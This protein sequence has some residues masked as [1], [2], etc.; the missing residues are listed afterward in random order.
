MS[1][2]EVVECGAEGCPSV[3]FTEVVTF[4]KVPAVVSQT[5]KAGIAPIGST[6]ICMNCGTDISETEAVKELREET[7]AIVT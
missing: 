1:E 3:M 2:Q 5:G 7:S 6:Y 4:T